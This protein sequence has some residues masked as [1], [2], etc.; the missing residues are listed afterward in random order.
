VR[1][2][3]SAA[4]RPRETAFWIGGTLTIGLG[5]T[6]AVLLVWAG[7]GVEFSSAYLGVALAVVLGAFF[8]YV[9]GAERRAR[10]SQSGEGERAGDDGPRG[11]RERPP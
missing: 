5:L 2:P 7:A 10:I 11:P 9:A 6:F 1:S 3:T 4:D 8:L